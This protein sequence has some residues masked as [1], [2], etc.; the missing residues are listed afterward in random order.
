[1]QDTQIQ[2]LIAASS[3]QKIAIDSLK[4]DLT[5]LSSQFTQFTSDVI[6]NNTQ[7]NIQIQNLVTTTD[8]QKL[9]LD[10]LRANL[11]SSTNSL[12]TQINTNSASISSLASSFNQLKVEVTSN[13]SILNT[14][15]QSAAASV[16]SQKLVTD[17]L[18]SDLTLN[19]NS[20]Q[21]QIN[22]LNSNLESKVNSLQSSINNI[23]N[24]NNAQ[25]A[26]IANL[27]NKGSL[28]PAQICYLNDQGY[29]PDIDRC[30]KEEHDYFAEYDYVGLVGLVPIEKCGTWVYAKEL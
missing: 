21:T 15:I 14:Q 22:T 9:V 23:N 18:R 7:Q 20:L 17:S 27:K 8:T 19:T 4:V 5:S 11:T 12:Q 13:N 28:S 25:N 3:S 16:N 2:N 29:C 6:S 26:E 24:V 30:C 10:Q 1:M